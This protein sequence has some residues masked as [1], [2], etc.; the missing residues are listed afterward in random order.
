MNGG[1]NYICSFLIGAL[2]FSTTRST[3]PMNFL[4]TAYTYD[5]NEIYFYKP[6]PA[7]GE[8]RPEGEKA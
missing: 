7:Q 3:S 1:E 2:N 6:K 8:R 4:A 5:K